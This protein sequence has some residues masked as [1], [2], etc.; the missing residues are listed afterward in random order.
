MP[1]YVISA[2]KKVGM[3]NHTMKKIALFL[4]LC[5]LSQSSLFADAYPV[6][7][8]WCGGIFHRK[9][10]V[11]ANTSVLSYT[12][13]NTGYDCSGR[14]VGTNAIGLWSKLCKNEDKGCTR[15][16]TAV[17]NNSGYTYDYYSDCQFAAASNP[18]PYYAYAWGELTTSY[19]SKKIK[20]TGRTSAG[21]TGEFELDPV[22]FDQL[23]ANGG[24]SAEISGDID[25]N[26]NNE[27]II[28]NLTGMLE[29]DQNVD[30]FSSLKIVIIK[31]NINIT[32]EEAQQNEE[33]VTTGVYGNIVYSSEIKVSKNSIYYDG[34][35]AGNNQSLNEWSTNLAKGIS[36]DSFNAA[37]PL[38]SNLAP[39]ERYTIITIIDG[40]FDISSSIVSSLS[41]GGDY[42]SYSNGETENPT[43][44][45]NYEK[46][47][48]T[49][50]IYP[51]PASS[52]I[53]VKMPLHAN[54]ATLEL[55]DNTGR[56]VLESSGLQSG[57][58]K[59]EIKHLPSGI[60]FY[61]VSI[62]G[63][64]QHGKLIKQ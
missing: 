50:S 45:A 35:F 47:A 15:P 56:K 12:K 1:Y 17:C 7:R 59:I 19:F 49:I 44:I 25:I 27:L 22:I 14:Y 9:F 40:G 29:V 60:Y 54:N 53:T 41:N 13:Y 36:L 2:L 20:T 31:E 23:N 48:T 52:A 51:S 21:Q 6:N 34:V 58:N 30:H 55:M 28:N 62:N 18:I 38:G 11:V 26:Q 33:A 24:S 8:K 37:V 5:L 3:R 16:R 64:S 32:N 61:T 43:G 10:V 42:D 46:A 57:E 63:K 4:L 39:D